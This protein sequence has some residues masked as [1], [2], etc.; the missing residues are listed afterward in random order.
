M[1][2]LILLLLIPFIVSCVGLKPARKIE[3]A[4]NKIIKYNTGINNQIERF[5]ALVTDAF[6]TVV[7]DSTL[8]SDSIVV[9]TALQDTEELLVIERDMDRVALGFEEARDVLKTIYVDNPVD[10][11]RLKKAVYMMESYKSQSD[12]LFQKYIQA[13]KLNNQ[14]GVYETDKYTAKWKLN[15]G[16]LTQDI[17]IKDKYVV[18]EKSRTT[19]TIDIRKD[20]WQDKKFYFLFLIPLLA[21]L[22]FLGGAIQQGLQSIVSTIFKF[23]R[24]M[25]TGGI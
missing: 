19:N 12:S 16:K 6:T 10:K 1:K 4:E 25:F 3:K 24:K 21:I 2:K 15:N 18:Y 8:V 7:L 11:A 23:I 13:A 20:F 17:K 9:E 14:F 22:F 5:P